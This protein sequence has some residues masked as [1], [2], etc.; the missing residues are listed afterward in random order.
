MAKPS[1]S[2]SVGD[3][4]INHKKDV[5][6]VQGL[7][8]GFVAAN[9]FGE[10]PILPI[11]GDWVATLP[12]IERF[13]K[14]HGFT[15]PDRK[16]DPDG[17]TWKDL[18]KHPIDP[19]LVLR[20]HL[21]AITAVTRGPL[22]TIRPEHWDAAM[23]ALIK[24]A[25]HE[26]LL[27]PEVV[28]FVDFKIKRSSPRLWVVN[29]E[30]HKLLLTTWVA[31]GSKSGGALAT[32]FDNG[33]QKSSLGAYA[34]RTS[35]RSSTLGHLPEGTSEPA[36]R[37]TGLEYGINHRA[38]E[39]GVLFHAATY[40]NP[41]VVGNS[42]GCFATPIKDNKVLVPMIADGTFVYAFYE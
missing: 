30:E 19:G 26:D 33:H 34:T 40:V 18:I 32:M 36:L 31:H 17:K 4:G 23:T 11:D 1:I 29:I 28:T 13:Q 2:A 9:Q 3:G 38:R 10:L 16:I 41:P 27:R 5:K 25:G 39:R 21:L 7:L 12:Y 6:T 37:L 22:S 35:Y 20:T 8:N 24:F 14:N 42:L 15:Y